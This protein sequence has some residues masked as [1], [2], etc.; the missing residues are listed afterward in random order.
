MRQ[1]TLLLFSLVIGTTI[2]VYTAGRLDVLMGSERAKARAETPPLSDRIAAGTQTLRERLG[3][4]AV[5]LRGESEPA[6][7]VI[8]DDTIETIWVWRDAEGEQYFS[9]N[10]PPADVQARE[11][12]YPRGMPL[13]NESTPQPVASSEETQPAPLQPSGQLTDLLIDEDGQSRFN[14]GLRNFRAMHGLDK[15]T[16][17]ADVGN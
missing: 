1:P 13:P 15:Q 4:W 6:T 11:I 2:M 5:A 3:R 8:S 10:A 14:E 16:S 7:V 9:R 12:L 17:E